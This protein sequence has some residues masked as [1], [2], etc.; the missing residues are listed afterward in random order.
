ML[1][2]LQ[3][4]SAQ[5]IVNIFETSQPLGDY[6]KVT[7]LAGDSGHLTY[8]RSQTTLASGNLFLLIKAYCEAPNAQFGSA[9]STFLSRLEDIDLVLDNDISFRELLRSAG[10]DPVMQ[11]VQDAFFDRVYWEPAAA[12]ANFIGS[13]SALGMAVVYDS[14]I[15][16]SWHRMRDRTTKKHGALK[17]LGEKKWMK[18]Y[19]KTRRD[20]LA[21]HSN[22]LLRKTVYRMDALKK[23]RDEGRW[24]LALPFTVRGIIVDAAA[25]TGRSMR[26]SAEVTEERLL[27]LRNPFMRGADVL[28][29]QKA[30]KNTGIAVDTDGVFGPATH[31][32]VL[33]FQQQN[34]LISDGVV[35]SA[36]R[37][38][39]RLDL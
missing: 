4:Q 15:H 25:L 22:K 8:G 26:V 1:S 14:R 35:G 32:A 11:E 27:R 24:D 34:A 16:G 28:T 29:V 12:S 31:A 13:K 23:L 37:T 10:D 5:A 30:L 2:D 38:S 3:K 39:L 19:V 21:N 6:G 9:L 36:T 7:L 20:W 33:E 17:D 18:R